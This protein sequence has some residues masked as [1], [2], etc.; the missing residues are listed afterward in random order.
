MT[1]SKKEILVGLVGNPNSGKTTIFNRLT[2]SRQKV[3]NWSGV[4]VEKREGILKHRDYRIRI[5]DLPGIYSLSPFSLEEIIT[6][7]FIL[8]EN[9]DIIINIVDAGN[10][11]R[12]LNLSTQLINIR[13]RM[14]IGLNMYDE[15]IGR[16]IYIDYKKLGSLLGM[17]VI[18]MVGSKGEGIGEL[19]EAIISM[20]EGTNDTVRHIH[21]PYGNDIE[22]EIR[23]I[24]SIIR[25]EPHIGAKYSTRWLAILL[26][27][28]DREAQ[29]RLKDYPIFNEILQRAAKSRL[30]IEKKYKED[31]FYLMS[32]ARQGFIAGALRE[33]IKMVEAPKRNITAIIDYLVL[34]KYLGYPILISFLWLLFQ[35]TYTLGEYPKNY[36]NASVDYLAGLLLSAIP[37]GAFRNL[38]VDGVLHGVGA[39]IVFLPNILILFLGVSFMEDSGYM[40]RAA[41]VMDRVMHRLGIHGKSFIPLIMG[42]GCN[43]PAIMATRA[44]ENQRD[45]IITILINPFMSCSARLPVY[46]LFAGVFFHNMAGTV[47]VSLYLIGVLFAFISARVFRILFFKGVSA[48]FVMELPPYRMPTVRTILLHMWSRASQYLK[49]IGGI[50]LLFSVIIWFLSN[51][52]SCLEGMAHPDITQTVPVVQATTPLRL[53][54]KHACTAIG[55][56]GK[57]IEPVLAPLGFNWKMGVSLITGIA[58]KEIVISTMGI[59]YQGSTEQRSSQASSLES[60][61]KSIHSGITPLSAYIYMLFVLLYIPCIATI[62]VIGKEIGWRWA[63]FS[64]VYNT[65]LTWIICFICHSAGVMLGFS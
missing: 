55:R 22:E 37:P 31:I 54:E 63:A 62:T 41:F 58:A 53:P 48:P 36:I 11:E 32:E 20:I 43:V 5:V 40:A 18:K 4:T 64:V 59:L 44:L 12:N 7:N 65:T 26:L 29:D 23:T 9:P 10:L 39:V 42:F 46:V 57:A 52:P 50:I 19:V 47:I 35:M 21:I 24:Q 60:S 45:R 1:S 61:L 14:I 49:K 28:N 25:K 16:G 27:E 34:N 33:T 2:G 3:A 17:P 13:A 38:I 15:A 51:Y 8:D 56:I 30:L 6:R